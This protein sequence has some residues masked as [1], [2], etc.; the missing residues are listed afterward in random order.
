MT[1]VVRQR[2]FALLWMAGLVSLLGDWAFYTVVPVLVLDETGS[3]FLAGVV[4]A[5][6]ALPSVVVGPVAGVYVDRWDR[7]RIMLWGNVA[8]AVA[9]AILVIA[10]DG[11]GIWVAMTVVL[12]NASLAAIILPAEHALLPTLVREEDLAPA[13]ALNAM[14]DNLARIVGPPVGAVIYTR[15]GIEA[16]AVVNAVSFLA[17][18]LLVRAV[19]QEGGHRRAQLERRA[20]ED[21]REP[22]WRSLRTGARIVRHHR[23]LGML[24]LVLGLVAF[25]DGPL[26]AMIAPFVD[27]TLGK[28]AAGVGVFAT[29]RG[30]AGIVGGVVIG[31][32]GP[33]VREDRLLMVSAAMNGLGFAA[34]ALGQDFAVACVI[35]VL[36][37]GPTHIGLHTTLMTLLQRGSE[38]AYRGRVF[39]LVGAVT[40]ALFLVG[41]VAGSVAGDHF[42]PAA[43]I[44]GS[45]LLFLVAALATALLLPAA[46]SGLPRAPIPEL[47]GTDGS[48]VS[49]EW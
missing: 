46:L 25:A 19:G 1:R 13:N 45:G 3:V 32:I 44:V 35:V 7:R 34:M 49:R 16:V 36:V 29:V 11:S 37:I 14:N 48:G 15:L 5:V 38:D 9:A 6:I 2:N 20:T 27:T 24:F 28:G 22:F 31:L 42:S 41:T 4:W 17:A 30:V 43:V 18:A 26:A 10:G 12:V 33:R 23:L 40:G 47:V 8:Q 21:G 39:A